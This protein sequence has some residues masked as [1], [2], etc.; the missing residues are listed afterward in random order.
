MTSKAPS[1]E[2]AEWATQPKHDDWA[3]HR[4]VITRLFKERLAYKDIATRMKQDFGFRAT[5]VSKDHDP[6]QEAERLCSHWI[7][8]SRVLI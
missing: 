6:K 5:Y 7:L 3:K 8:T 1:I 4:D 2:N